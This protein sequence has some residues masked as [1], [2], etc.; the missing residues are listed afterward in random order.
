[1]KSPR[2]RATA[3]IALFFSILSVALLLLSACSREGPI[4][5]GVLL[6]RTGGLADVAENVENSLTL[7]VEK[8]N[9][10][11]G[12]NG[13]D[14]RLIIRD[15]KMNPAVGVRAFEEIEAEHAPLFY[16]SI[17]SLNSVALA[18][19]AE[20]AKAPLFGLITTSSGLTQRR[21][22]V[23]RYYPD[24]RTELE[25]IYK[26]IKSFGV[27]SLGI[28]YSDEEWGKDMR[29]EITSEVTGWSNSPRVFSIP[30]PLATQDF[31]S[32]AARAG[33][34]EGIYISG[35]AAHL[36]GLLD[37]LENSGY[38]GDVFGPSTLSIPEIRKTGKADGCYIAAPK[39]YSAEYPFT[40]KIKIRY[41]ER[42][43]ES[44]NH[45][46]A[47][48]YDFLMLITSL[49]QDEEVSRNNLKSLFDRGFTYSGILGLINVE[50]GERDIAFP[51]FPARIEGDEIRYLAIENE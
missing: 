41:E 9:S 12:I 31:S 15:T 49:L 5:A 44:F 20:K 30:Y 27:G 10:A 24:V 51:L 48:A 18:P 38:S 7:A 47:N 43:G 37:A 23:F 19:A 21:E 32:Y 36:E 16:I 13:R 45:Y 1:M 35:F 50:P 26:I 17:I 8:I 40:E 6:P 39:N 14:L 11:G 3:T 22:W 28:I 25:P 29:R 46:G 42:Y 33:S 2:Y 4:L 34:A